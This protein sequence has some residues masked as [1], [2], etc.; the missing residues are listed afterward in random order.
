VHAAYSGVVLEGVAADGT[1]VR[2][3]EQILRPDAASW[4]YANH[5]RFGGSFLFRGG[6]FDRHDD[7]VWEGLDAQE[8]V[9]G[10]LD[11]FMHGEILPT[12]W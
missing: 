7:W 5:H 3:V 2:R 10:A 12:E 11:A 6:L 9:L 4:I 1:K 8:H